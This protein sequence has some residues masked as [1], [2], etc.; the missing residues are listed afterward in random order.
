VNGEQIVRMGRG[1]HQCI[2]RRRCSRTM[3]LASRPKVT[4]ALRRDHS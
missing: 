3:V 4:A 1:L 2:I